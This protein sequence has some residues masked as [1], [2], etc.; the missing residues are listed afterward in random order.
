MGNKG[1][2][3]PCHSLLYDKMIAHPWI[4]IWWAASVGAM[5]N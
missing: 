3:A 1:A 4:Q 2:Q 5:T